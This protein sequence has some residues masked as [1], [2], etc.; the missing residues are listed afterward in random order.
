MMKRM[1][2]SL[3]VAALLTGSGF[4]TYGFGIP[5]DAPACCNPPQNCCPKSSCCSS[6][7]NAH[8]PMHAH[9]S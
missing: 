3:F 9:H 2:F 7:Q 5:G 4:G 1:I 6:G 8:C